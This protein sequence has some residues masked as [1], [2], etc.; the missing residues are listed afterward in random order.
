MGLRLL[1]RYDIDFVRGLE[2]D[3]A[4]FQREKCKITALAYKKAWKIAGPFLADKNTARGD[5]LAAVTLHPKTLG[6]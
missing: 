5:K 4:I 1:G 6:M 2:A 3:D